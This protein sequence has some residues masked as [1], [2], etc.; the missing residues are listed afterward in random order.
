MARAGGPAGPAARGSRRMDSP[1][2]CWKI[3]PPTRTQAAVVVRQ[4]V[5]VAKP[6]R[7][8]PHGC[9]KR[10][11]HRTEKRMHKILAAHDC[12]GRPAMHVIVHAKGARV[13]GLGRFT[14]SGRMGTMIATSVP[15]P[16]HELSQPCARAV[17]RTALCGR[18]GPDEDARLSVSG[19]G[20]EGGSFQS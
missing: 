13:P 20:S 15:V 6:P 17:R 19:G 8:V 9:R 14:T 2:R 18:S 10:A 4:L 5:A 11:D 3:P 7:S 12:L 16:V 1:Q